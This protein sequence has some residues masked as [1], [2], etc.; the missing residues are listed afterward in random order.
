MTRTNIDIDDELIATVMKQNAL[1]TKREAVDFALRKVV[2]PTLT[3]EEILALQGS[4]KLEG[5]EELMAGD[6]ERFSR[7]RE[8]MAGVDTE[9]LDEDANEVRASED[10]RSAG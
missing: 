2:R 10:R 9:R 3:R 7:F 5:H 6:E 1:T 8:A 4:M